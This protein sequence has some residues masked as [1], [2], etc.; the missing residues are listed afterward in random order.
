MSTNTLF[1]FVVFWQVPRSLLLYKIFAML[2][3]DIRIRIRSRVIRIRVN[4]ACSR[5][6]IRVTAK[7]DTPKANNPFFIYS[8]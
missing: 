5:A 8:K 6:V 1:T 2:G 7:Q 4:E 3:A